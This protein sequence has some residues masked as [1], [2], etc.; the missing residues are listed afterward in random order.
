MSSYLECDIRKS[1]LEINRTPSLY[2]VNAGVGSPTASQSNV[3]LPWMSISSFS[4]GGF[5]S[6]H[7]G[8]TMEEN[9][10]NMHDCLIK[11]GK[12]PQHNSHV[13]QFT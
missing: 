6:L 10:S 1:Y 5:E 4:G 12:V 11:R 3:P 2:H 7:F 13:I 8:A 9:V